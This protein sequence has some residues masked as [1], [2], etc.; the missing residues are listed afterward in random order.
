MLV[1][2]G[3]QT[4][5]ETEIRTNSLAYKFLRE[6]LTCM[7]S[8]RTFRLSYATECSYKIEIQHNDHGI[9]VWS[10][11]T[12]FKPIDIWSISNS[13]DFVNQFCFAKRRMLQVLWFDGTSFEGFHRFPHTGLYWYSLILVFK[14]TYKQCWNMIISLNLLVAESRERG[15]YWESTLVNCSWH[16]FQTSF[17]HKWKKMIPFRNNFLLDLTCECG[18]LKYDVKALLRIFS[19]KTKIKNLSCDSLFWLRYRLE[20]G[21]RGMLRR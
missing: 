3:L 1:L 19:I 14:L 5:T 13:S 11:F 9:Y 17:H 15:R 12:D 8:S 2:Q 7:L 4:S 20:A 16:A 10:S 18:A 6:S 21:M